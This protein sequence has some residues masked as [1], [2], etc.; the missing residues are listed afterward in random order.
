ME[1]FCVRHW[2][3]ELSLFENLLSFKILYLSLALSSQH[4]ASKVIVIIE[5]LGLYLGDCM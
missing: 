1:T 2:V 3:Q 4:S 5:N